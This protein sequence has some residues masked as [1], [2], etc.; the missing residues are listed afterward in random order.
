ME[1]RL[2][3]AALSASNGLRNE[4]SSS[5]NA[6]RMTTPM[7]IGSREETVFWK[8]IVAAVVPVTKPVA[9]SACSALGSTSSCSRLTSEA[10]A[11]LCGPVVGTTLPIRSL[12]SELGWKAVTEATPGSPLSVVGSDCSSEER[13]WS[14]ADAG[15]LT[16]TVSGPLA[17]GP[18]PPRI[19]SKAW[20]S[21]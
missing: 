21:L 2:S 10:V 6:A 12:P 18:N 20:R 19:A 16:T 7:M 3:N 5:R 13:C 11:S 8:S 14:V 1:S 9:W 15:S 4:A 17:P